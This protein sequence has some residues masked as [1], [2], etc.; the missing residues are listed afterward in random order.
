[1]AA[2][3]TPAG[4][5]WRCSSGTLQRLLPPPV[6]SGAG[7]AAAVDV[8]AVDAAAAGPVGPADSTSPSLW[9]ACR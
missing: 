6:A 8:A 4:D 9:T 2:I 7:A 1:V 3:G 5:C